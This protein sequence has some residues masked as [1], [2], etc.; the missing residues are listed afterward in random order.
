MIRNCQRKGLKV[1]LIGLNLQQGSGRDKLLKKLRTLFRLG[2][3][4]LYSS[5]GIGVNNDL[6]IINRILLKYLINPIRDLMAFTFRAQ[7]MK[8]LILKNQI[9][10][11]IISKVKLPTTELPL[12][13]ILI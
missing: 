7:K 12:L 5:I 2:S 3:T 8:R 9:S 4:I 1:F 6:A 10:N 11:K 13:I